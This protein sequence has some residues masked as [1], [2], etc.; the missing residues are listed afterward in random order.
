MKQ[1]YLGTLEGD[2]NDKIELEC[3]VQDED[4][5]CD[6]YFAGEVS[7]NFSFTHSFLRLFSIEN[8]SGIRSS[9]KY[10]V[11]SYGKVR[12]L[13][14]KKLHPIYDKGKYE[15]K[16]GVMTTT[17]DV[18]VR[19]KDLFPF[20]ISSLRFKFFFLAALCIERGLKDVDTC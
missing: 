15:C 11:I 8:S 13:V 17:C 19:R 4:A 3:S 1:N 2:E 12:K 9:E 14:V 10:E 5:E 7:R 18:S 6:W 20:E 16:T